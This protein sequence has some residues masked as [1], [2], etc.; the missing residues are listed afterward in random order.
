M[1]IS[2]NKVFNVTG[3]HEYF[4]DMYDSN[5]VCFLCNDYINVYML[6]NDTIT[7]SCIRFV[8]ATLWTDET[9]PCILRSIN[10]F[11]VI[12]GLTCA[13]SPEFHRE[14]LDYIKAA[15]ADVVITHHS[16]SFQ[17]VGAIFRNSDINSCFASE[18]D[19]PSNTD[20]W[21]H[22]HM[23]NHSDYVKGHTRIVCNPRG[24]PNEQFA[25]DYN[26]SVE[27]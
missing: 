6:N 5:S 14:S 25:Y 15:K 13:N 21:I 20:L 3:N 9:D 16:P 12:D 23:H 18:L 7:I 1:S 24:Y 26:F 10:D 27:I 4:H 2:C 22:G 8:G 19:M 17:S 11:R